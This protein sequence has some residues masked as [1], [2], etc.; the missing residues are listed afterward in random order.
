MGNSRGQTRN[1]N[2]FGVK[3]GIERREQEGRMNKKH[4]KRIRTQDRLC[5]RTKNAL[6]HE[7]DGD[8]NVCG[9]AWNGPKGFVRRLEELEIGGRAVI[10]Q[11]SSFFRSVGYWEES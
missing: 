6:N 10:I 4:E 11:T 3:D 5:Q 7:D 9:C 8:T 1:L 2:N